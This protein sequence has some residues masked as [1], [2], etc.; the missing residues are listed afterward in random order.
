MMLKFYADRLTVTLGSPIKKESVERNIS[1]IQ[2]PRA[3]KDFKLYA[4]TSVPE[5]RVMF[6]DPLAPFQSIPGAHA[7]ADSTGIPL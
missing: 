2:H 7:N 3:Y 1:M 6:P 4:E 5:F